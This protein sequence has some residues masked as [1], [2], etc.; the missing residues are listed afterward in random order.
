MVVG[1]EVSP[2]L[3]DV[4]IEERRRLTV[5]LCRWACADD[6][7][8]TQHRRYLDVI[9][10]RRYIPPS[11]SCG[12]LPHWVYYRL[13]VRLGWI[14]RE[15][16]RGWRVGVNINRLVPPPIGAC[17]EAFVWSGQPLG[18]GDTIVIANDWGGGRDAHAVVVLVTHGDDVATAEYGQPGGAMYRRRLHG[19]RL[20][21]VHEDGTLSAGRVVRA[22]LPLDRVLRSAFQRGLLAEPTP[23]EDLP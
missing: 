6:R 7:V 16:H 3:T 11:S 22:W 17:S 18:M 5:R 2:E 20:C 19:N 12:D 14:N 4:D 21:A 15:E 10:H 23:P 13:G 9:E 8:D 1:G